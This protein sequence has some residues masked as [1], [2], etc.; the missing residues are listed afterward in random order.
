MCRVV[1][2]VSSSWP[3]LAGLGESE[4]KGC[5]GPCAAHE[6][7]ALQQ[8]GDGVPLHGSGLG[9]SALGDVVHQHPETKHV[10][11]LTNDVHTTRAA[12]GA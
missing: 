5:T 4:V 11:K 1:Y 2:V 6:V 9:I 10:K 8:D 3:S 7:S 12:H